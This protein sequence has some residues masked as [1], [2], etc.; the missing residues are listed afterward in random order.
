MMSF[1]LAAESKKILQKKR[2][3]QWKLCHQN[4]A[5]CYYNLNPGQARETGTDPR[6][7][8]PSRPAGVNGPIR[9]GP[10]PDSRDSDRLGQMDCHR[11]MIRVQGPGPDPG[12]GLGSGP[13]ARK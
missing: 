12:P 8:D 9:V 13:G 6:T 5:L 7:R 11:Q 1:S 3:S 4:E 2:D 10:R